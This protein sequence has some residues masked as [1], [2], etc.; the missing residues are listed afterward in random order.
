MLTLNRASS[1]QTVAAILEGLRASN[2]A[3]LRNL[4]VHDIEGEIL[5]RGRVRTYFM[6]QMAFFTATQAA[7]GASIRDEIVVG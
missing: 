3:Q 4:A 7:S 2:Y 5:L 1:T 6:K